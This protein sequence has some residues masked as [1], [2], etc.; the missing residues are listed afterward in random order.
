M[1]QMT[2]SPFPAQRAAGKYTKGARAASSPA[3]YHVTNLNASGSGSFK[4]AVSKSGQDY[5]F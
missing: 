5:C 1:G 4:D 3:V 2:L